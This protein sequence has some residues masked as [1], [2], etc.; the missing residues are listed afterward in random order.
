MRARLRLHAEVV[1]LERR[2]D[3]AGVALLRDPDRVGALSLEC[4]LAVR[5]W[6]KERSIRDFR[7]A[8][9]ELIEDKGPGG[10]R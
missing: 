3:D 8:F 2:V 10:R 4:R 6:D 5:G 1:A 7:A 9:G